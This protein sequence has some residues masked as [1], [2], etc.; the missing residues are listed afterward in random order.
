MAWPRSGAWATPSVPRCSSSGS[1]GPGS[2]PGRT[3]LATAAGRDVGLAVLSRIPAEAQGR[4][5][6]GTV[7]SDPTPERGALHV[8]AR[9]RRDQGRPHRRAPSSRLPYGPPIQLR[10][11]A[12]Q[13]PAARPPRRS[14]PATATSGVPPCES[15][16]PGWR[17]AVRGRTWPAGRPHSQIDHILVRA[18]DGTEV[19][20]SEVLPG[21]RVRPPP[22]AGDAALRLETAAMHEQQRVEWCRV[23][24]GRAGR[25]PRRSSSPTRVR[26]RP[27]SRCRRAASATPTST[28]ARARST[29][30]SRSC[31][32]TRR[33]AWSSRSAP[34][35]P[36]SRP[37]TSSIL[38]WRAVCGTCRA[39]RRGR[40]W[41]CFATFNATQKMT[42]TDGTELRPALG[43]G[44]FAE[45]DAR[46]RR[47][48]H[49][50][51]PRAPAPRPP[52][53][54]AAA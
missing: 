20:D 27:G 13:L 3:C 4:L 31:S 47:P 44:A 29:T 42:L 10:R 51:R 16:L 45:Q 12:A 26:A 30:S 5:S 52:A 49:Q 23:A 24:Q 50:G 33:R 17:R 18:A 19:A 9:R 43:I 41:Y 14:S 1:V 48:G 8:G 11:L 21:R 34:T 54:S 25:D 40:P 53:C 22:G 39:C 35:S 2:I 7:L 15:F 36:R 46:R 6:V 32:G 37:A 38:N 28:T